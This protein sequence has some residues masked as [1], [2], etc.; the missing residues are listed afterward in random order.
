MLASD[1]SGTVWKSFS[2]SSMSVSRGGG[3]SVRMTF[4]KGS[5]DV[6]PSRVC[7]YYTVSSNTKKL[8][9]YQFENSHLVLVATLLLVYRKDTLLCAICRSIGRL[10]MV[11]LVENHLYIKRK[12]H[13]ENFK[14]QRHHS[15]FTFSFTGW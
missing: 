6:I 14:T 10:Q 1:N 5:S 13:L 4:L 2:L 7:Y 8:I 3:G 11:L 9:N 12:N 15:R